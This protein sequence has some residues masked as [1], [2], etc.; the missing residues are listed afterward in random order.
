[1]E[2]SVRLISRLRKSMPFQNRLGDYSIASPISTTR[3]TRVFD[4]DYRLLICQNHTWILALPKRRVE[5]Q[6]ERVG[7]R[8]FWRCGTTYH[9]GLDWTHTHA[10]RYLRIRWSCISHYLVLQHIRWHR[11]HRPALSLRQHN[12]QPTVVRARCCCTF[13]VQIY[14]GWTKEMETLEDTRIKIF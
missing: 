9:V 12:P 3:S 7:T 11:I 14:N 8:P 1:L 2:R 5:M 13:R 4:A 10:L 6:T